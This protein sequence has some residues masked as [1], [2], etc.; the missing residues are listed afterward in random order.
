[1]ANTVYVYR[2]GKIVEIDKSQ[3]DQRKTVAVLSGHEKARQTGI[4]MVPEASRMASD[5]IEAHQSGR[6]LLRGKE[7]GNIKEI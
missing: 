5:A 2:D 6:K 7:R 3:L 4:R 1:M